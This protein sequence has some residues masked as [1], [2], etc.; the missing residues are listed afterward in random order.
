MLEIT[1]PQ[2]PRKPFLSGIVIG[3]IISVVALGICI[4][5][6]INHLNS[7]P[8]QADNNTKQPAETVATEKPKDD[9]TKPEDKLE[10]DPTDDPDYP[11]KCNDKLSTFAIGYEDIYFGVEDCFARSVKDFSR[12]FTFNQADGQTIPDV[13]SYLR[14]NTTKT[15]ATLYAKYETDD[16]AIYLEIEGQVPE[17]RQNE[18]VL[19]NELE[20][21]RL[22]VTSKKTK[23]ILVRGHRM[24]FFDS[25]ASNITES[26]E[27]SSYE[28]IT[29]KKSGADFVSFEI[30]SNIITFEFKNRHAQRGNTLSS[31][32][33]ESTYRR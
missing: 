16:D 27:G 32:I 11:L 1:E 30:Y 13:Y 3:E 23:D 10:K 9:E 4:F 2:S 12:L 19:L 22:V 14:A 8:T 17:E 6:V 20:F 33:V 15:T 7:T 24:R 21:T 26:F 28:N 31:I 25:T 29:Q 5:A 18:D